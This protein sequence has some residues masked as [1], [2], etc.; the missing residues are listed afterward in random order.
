MAIAM[1]SY[2]KHLAMDIGK[3]ETKKLLKKIAGTLCLAL[4]SMNLIACATTHPTTEMDRELALK[5]ADKTPV[6]VTAPA[7]VI[8]VN[9]F[10]GGQKQETP[11]YA[12]QQEV[13]EY[14]Q[15]LA[16]QKAAQS[17]SHESVDRDAVNA[18]QLAQENCTESPVYNYA[19][20]LVKTVRRCFGAR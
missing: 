19:G 6:V 18:Q 17:G 3:G 10:N 12:T 20:Q 1:A 16:D 9:N 14:A 7:P 11:A 8:N 4:M 13:E 5:L 2:A 15:Y